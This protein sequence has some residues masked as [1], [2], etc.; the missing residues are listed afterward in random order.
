MGEDD[1]NN[2]E[3]IS[4]D[5]SKVKG[6]FKKEKKAEPKETSEPGKIE[7]KGSITE[8]EEAP[9]T[10]KESDDIQFNL[11]GIKNI[12]KGNEW[13]GFWKKYGA[14]VAII[15]AILIPMLFS[16]HFRMYPSNL[17]ATDEWARSSIYNSYRSQIAS[18]INQQYPNLPEANKNA[19]VDQEFEK[20]IKAQGKEIEDQIKG[21]SDYFKS[22]FKDDDG[23]TYLLAIDPYLWYGEAR[24]YLNYGHLGDKKVN[25]TSVY[26]LRDGRV[27]KLVTFQFH[28]FFEAMLY[29]VVHFFNGSFTL[30]RAA[31]LTPLILI[32][33]SVIP[34]FF[35]VKRFGGVVGGLFAGSIL[36]YRLWF[37]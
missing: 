34:V 29:R 33:L 2:D 36:L 11:S 5:F 32:T 20:I 17:P 31:F 24:N 30:L 1:N 19:L 21:T 13:A 23:Q 14:A 12:F 18:Q 3:D 22:R 8:E 6:W 28:P 37:L 27:D 16:I 4:I 25:G 10:E 7:V 35:I 15:I 9:T 26:T